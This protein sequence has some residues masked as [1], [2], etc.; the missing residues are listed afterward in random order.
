MKIFII[1]TIRNFVSR[2]GLNT[3][4]MEYNSATLVFRRSLVVYLIAYFIVISG[5]IQSSA[6]G[7]KILVM[8]PYKQFTPDRNPYQIFKAQVC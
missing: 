8:L 2:F 6:E 1:F 4:A 7:L 5:K 3:C